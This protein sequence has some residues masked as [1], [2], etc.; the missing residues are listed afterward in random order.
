[1]GGHC[2]VPP[3]PPNEAI[4][5]LASVLG[6]DSTREIVRLFLEDFPQSVRRLGDGKRED[7]VMIAHGLKS[8]ALHMGATG[9]SKRMAAIETKLSATAE[10]LSPGELSAAVAEF[11]AVE[12]MLRGYAGS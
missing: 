7:Q 3:P 1:L 4:E 8:S 2:G 12:P 11:E 5:A 9:L 6:E 10:T